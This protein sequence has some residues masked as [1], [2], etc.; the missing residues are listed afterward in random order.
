MPDDFP[1]RLAAYHGDDD[2]DGEG[3][4]SPGAV[5]AGLLWP[6][7][8]T[9]RSAAGDRYAASDAGRGDYA[10]ACEVPFA[11][12][13]CTS[14]LGVRREDGYVYARHALVPPNSGSLLARVRGGTSGYDALG[15]DDVEDLVAARRRAVASG[16]DTRVATPR[17]TADPVGFELR[18]E[19]RETGP[20]L[21]VTAYDDGRDYLST[22]LPDLAVRAVRAERDALD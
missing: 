15:V 11:G 4:P 8:G 22:P 18:F 19:T 2:G 12:E 13:D 6:I 10:Y 20:P 14:R 17:T 3:L 5:L 9:D 21:S 7:R 1:T 16:L